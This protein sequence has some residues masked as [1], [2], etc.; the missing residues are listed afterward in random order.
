[1]PVFVGHC[2]GEI[3]F[4]SEYSVSLKSRVEPKTPSRSLKPWT[5]PN[6]RTFMLALEESTGYVASLWSIPVSSVTL[7]PWF[8]K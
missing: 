5:A 8:H 1:M 3:G 4:N 6:T 7:A 2:V